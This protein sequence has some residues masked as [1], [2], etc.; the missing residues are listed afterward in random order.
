MPR[1]RLS[2]HSRLLTTK[3][4][5]WELN[6]IEEYFKENPHATPADRDIYANVLMEERVKVSKEWWSEAERRNSHQDYKRRLTNWFKN[7]RAMIKKRGGS[8]EPHPTGS[9]DA[10]SESS[11]SPTDQVE[12]VAQ[13]SRTC[14]IAPVTIGT[15]Q[16]CSKQPSVSEVYRAAEALIALRM[17]MG[18]SW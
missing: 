7:K 13:E 4:E 10:L 2:T 12:D 1:V 14:L 17:N 18:A 5:K 16:L 15:S 11:A 6:M 3:W 9:G 8:V